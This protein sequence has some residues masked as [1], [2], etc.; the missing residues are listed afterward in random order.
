MYAC[1]AIASTS[2]V[3]LSQKA[4]LSL[5][6]EEG[7]VPELYCSVCFHQNRAMPDRDV[8]SVINAVLC[9]KN[10]RKLRLHWPACCKQAFTVTITAQVFGKESSIRAIKKLLSA[11][12]A[13]RTC[14]LTPGCRL[15]RTA[16][17][18][19][20]NGCNWDCEGAD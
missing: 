18:A 2:T 4:L 10:A 8:S 9:K 7:A 3:C 13:D 5:V 1:L 16:V 15:R 6:K 12:I 19:C 17:A 20:F 11:T 14:F